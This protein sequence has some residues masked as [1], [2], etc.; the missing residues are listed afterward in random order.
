MLM[1]VNNSSTN[2]WHQDYSLSWFQEVVV[3]RGPCFSEREGGLHWRRHI[4]HSFAYL[5]RLWPSKRNSEENSECSNNKTVSNSIIKDLHYNVMLLEISWIRVRGH[6]LW[7]DSITNKYTYSTIG[8]DVSLSR[9]QFLSIN[10]RPTEHCVACNWLIWVSFRV[11]EKRYPK[12]T[13][14]RLFTGTV[15]C[16]PANFSHFQRDIMY[17]ENYTPETDSISTSILIH[18]G[19]VHFK[20]NKLVTIWSTRVLGVIAAVKQNFLHPSFLVE[21]QA[22]L[23][24]IWSLGFNFL[25]HENSEPFL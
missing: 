20:S 24:L 16:I 1:L 13:Y 6:G 4:S 10:L 8:C 12:W 23:Q 14:V 19:K 9:T 3:F 2:Y 7:L 21:Y 15:N 11:D 17:N 5:S 25:I 22:T 18:Q